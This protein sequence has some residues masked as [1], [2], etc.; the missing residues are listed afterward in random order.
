MN[1]GMTQVKMCVW[2]E[3]ETIAGR[4]GGEKVKGQSGFEGFQWGGDEELEV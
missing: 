1:P 4:K 3:E 2:R